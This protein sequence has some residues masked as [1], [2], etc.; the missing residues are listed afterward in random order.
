MAS[1]LKKAYK[2]TVVLDAI[3][4]DVRTGTVFSLLGPNGAG[5][6]TTVNVLT[7]LLR[8]D[9]GTARVAGYD[10]AREPRKVRSSIGVT[11]QFASV[12]ELLSGRENLQLM[13]DLHHFNA[14]RARTSS[15]I[16]CGASSWRIQPTSSRRRTPVV[17]AASWTWR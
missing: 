14:A 13:V 4:L 10:V 7:T 1:G 11:G 16:C 3:D 15:R 8:I 2:N 17:C 5:K 9:G 12:D 6:T